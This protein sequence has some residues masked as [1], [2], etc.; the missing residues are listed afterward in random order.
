MT[1]H[2]SPDGVKGEFEL[3]AANNA[4]GISGTVFSASIPMTIRLLRPLPYGG[5]MVALAQKVL[6]LT[7]ADMK[8]IGE[9][10]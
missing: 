5:L 4:G 7:V 6:P 2:A 8:A 10:G 9:K 3:T 1:S